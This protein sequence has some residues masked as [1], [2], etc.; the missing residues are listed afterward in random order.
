VRVGFVL[1]TAMHFVLML[2]IVF[3]DICIHVNFTRPIQ[4]TQQNRALRILPACLCDIL[5][6]TVDQSGFGRALYET[7]RK[8]RLLE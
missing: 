8:P 6:G 5:I 2:C 4:N 7:H 1:D 3:N